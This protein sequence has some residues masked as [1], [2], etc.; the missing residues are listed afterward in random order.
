MRFSLTVLICCSFAPFVSLAQPVAAASATEQS[1][2]SEYKV[3][4]E[5]LKIWGPLAR[6]AGTV[7]AY[8]G[9]T[10]LVRR[11]YWVNGGSGIEF[12]EESGAAAKMWVF[13]AGDEPGTLLAQY[14]FV[15]DR[16]IADRDETRF[17][18]VD[19]KTAISEWYKM[20]GSVLTRSRIFYAGGDAHLVDSIVS[21]N[22]SKPKF[23]PVEDRISWWMGSFERT[24]ETEASI[25][26]AEQKAKWA[27]A[28][29]RTKEEMRQA[30]ARREAEREAR[31]AERSAMWGSIAMG[32]IQGASQAGSEY[33]ADRARQDAFLAETARQAEAAAEAT[34][35]QRQLQQQTMVSNTPANASNTPTRPSQRPS[36]IASTASSA[37]FAASGNGATTVAASVSQPGNGAVPVAAKPLRF[38]LSVQMESLPEDAGA[39]VVCHSGIVTR[40]GPPGWGTVTHHNH[41]LGL[42][43]A[44]KFESAFLA[45]CRQSGQGRKVLQDRLVEIMAND[46]SEES[47]DRWFDGARIR[48]GVKVV[49][50]TLN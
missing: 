8:R 20:V 45:K 41:E 3:T 16:G 23:P 29:E 46:H 9:S 32:A 34:R 24:T 28:L 25:L 42:A 10:S 21:E 39:A 5:Q 47:F 35:R 19:D 14:R 4:A 49:S 44:R 12:T 18:I 33:Q 7:W 31:R 50:V 43:E 38:W 48:D 40:P 11:F 13:Q 37:P 26:V 6:L 2:M 22:G 36:S 30:A 15:T 1:P 27:Q 17:R